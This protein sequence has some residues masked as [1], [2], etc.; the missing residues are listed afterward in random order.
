MDESK[1][2]G[3]QRRENSWRGEEGKLRFIET[4]LSN[5][6]RSGSLGRVHSTLLCAS[7]IEEKARVKAAMM[8]ILNVFSKYD[9]EG[10]QEHLN[11]YYLENNVAPVTEHFVIP[12]SVDSVKP[13]NKQP[14]ELLPSVWREHIYPG[15]SSPGNMTGVLIYKSI[16]I[17][18]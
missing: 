4:S 7:E 8:L 3:K 10:I 12:F 17:C 18:G 11:T 1:V 16:N 6:E 2:K 9:G 15:I 14:K 5:S 13:P